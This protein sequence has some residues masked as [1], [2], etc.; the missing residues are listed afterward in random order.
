[1]EIDQRGTEDNSHFRGTHH[2][3]VQETAHLLIVKANVTTLKT[4]HI[5][6]MFPYRYVEK[7]SAFTVPKACQVKTAKKRC[8]KIQLE[9]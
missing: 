5:K 6:V 9:D 4:N 2:F 8:Q 1:M 7:D 3:K